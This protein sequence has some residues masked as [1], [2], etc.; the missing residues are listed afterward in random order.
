MN[1]FKKKY[2]HNMEYFSALKK[3]EVLQCDHMDE[4]WGWYKW[5]KPVT[6]GQILHDSTHI[7]YLK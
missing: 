2:I 4:T 6:E 7:K 3:K 1:A 5:N